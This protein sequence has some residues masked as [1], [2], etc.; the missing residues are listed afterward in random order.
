MRTR[1]AAGLIV[2]LAVCAP[3]QAATSACQTLA[4]QIDTKTAP[5]FL[6]SYPT[7]V[8]GP[9][10]GVA[11]LYDNAA[12]TIALIGCG[13]TA[14]ARRIGDAMLWALDH[15]RYWHDG[16]LRNAYIAGPATDAPLKLPGWWDAKQNKWIED[17]YQVGSDSGNLAWAMLALI[18]LTRASH[19][20]RYLTAAERIGAHV[21]QSFD[22]HAPAGFS[23][24]VLGGEP[25]PMPYKWK[26]TEHNTDLAA[27]FAQLAAL[28]HDNRWQMQSERAAR[29]V[30]GMWRADCSCFDAGSG[31]DG[32]ARN[33]FRALDAQLWPWLAIPGATARYAGALASARRD[34][35]VRGGFAYSQSKDAVWTEGTAQAALLMELSKQD[36]GAALAA[37]ERNRAPDGYYAVDTA[38]SQTSFLLDTDRSKPRAYFHMPHLAALAWAALAQTRLNPFTGSGALP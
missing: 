19:D 27:A 31:E 30:D 8:S 35:G 28:T 38:Q 11:F 9:L 23:G 10:G 3:A 36:A 26:S 7:Q 21:A 24:G 25:S 16:R 2:A 1:L 14:K 12:A 37:I 4:G 20:A 29:F 18:A 34:M 13:E 5:L 22:P 33:P 6:A 15:D 17:Q 32:A